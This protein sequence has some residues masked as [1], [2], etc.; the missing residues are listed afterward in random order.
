M[1]K[2]SGSAGSEAASRRG[3][4]N[5]VRPIAG[6]L[7]AVTVA[8]VIATAVGLFAG[9]FTTSVP[10]TVV[11]ARAGLVMNPDAKVKLH[12][13]E[14]GRVASIAS[15]PDGQ[16]ALQL[17]MNPSWMHVIPANVGVD[18]ASS[19]VF[20]A[21]F[22]ELTEPPNPSPASLHAGQTLAGKQVTVEINTVFQQLTS[23][24]SK[25]E[26]AKLS[27]TLGAL[28][29]AF[30]GR[31]REIGQMLSDFDAF[32]AKLDPSRPMLAHDLA[33][34]PA[35]LNA[36]ADAAPDLMKTA[37]NAT[38]ISR[39]IVEE[40]HNLDALLISTIGLSDI[41]TQVLGE[42]RKPLTD[43]THLLLPTTELLSSYH[44]A[45]TCGISGLSFW[46]KQGAAK[47][48]GITLLIGVDFGVE[49]YR[50]PGD[51][52]R[53][54]AKG[55]PQCT[56]LPA[57][58]FQGHAPFVIADVGANPFRYGNQGLMWNSDLLK[59]WLFGPVDGPPRNSAQIGQSG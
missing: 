39:T 12:G 19:T 37:D 11:S 1:T 33:V 8:A 7:T 31:G 4:V 3:A 2:A 30:H 10:V 35:A 25:V 51:L 47:D 13:V 9:D 55:G 14:V 49:R 32:L 42:N 15:L 38:R 54:A 27:E 17:A 43:V 23:V 45:L 44:Q 16:A 22:V 46:S 57:M 24:L 58:P 20:G 34:A 50:Y 52:P 26:P 36:Y 59:Q 28:S 53:V 48:P 21:K 6:L 56:D 40:Q 29:S 41:G 18:I 5:W